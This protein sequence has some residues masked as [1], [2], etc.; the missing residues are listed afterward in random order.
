MAH[1]RL[2]R[3]LAT[4][5]QLPFDIKTVAPLCFPGRILRL[6][7]ADARVSFWK[8]WDEAEWA[9]GIAAL[10]LMGYWPVILITFWY[11][12]GGH[13]GP[14]AS[15]LMTQYR[16]NSSWLALVAGWC[17]MIFAGFT[18]DLA[19]RLVIEVMVFP[20]R[21]VVTLWREMEGCW[22]T[23]RQMRRLLWPWLGRTDIAVVYRRAVLQSYFQRRRFGQDELLEEL[24]REQ[25]VGLLDPFRDDALLQFARRPLTG[26]ALAALLDYS[27]HHGRLEKEILSILMT[28]GR[29]P[30][31]T[32]ARPLL[33]T[34]A[35]YPPAKLAALLCTIAQLDSE[36]HTHSLVQILRDAQEDRL[37]V[38]LNFTEA[39][40]Q[41]PLAVCEAVAG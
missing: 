40:T 14:N 30:D 19:R 24:I 13:C 11:C 15:W 28:S 9:S 34:M 21:F 29:F 7:G 17:M 22:R 32:S 36:L 8:G 31:R 27:I 16:T 5:R 35:S 18:I 6:A 38:V 3:A 25:R 37:P 1:T 2:P 10:L 20:G 39:A 41:L 23:W 12:N 26:A 33:Q 4:M